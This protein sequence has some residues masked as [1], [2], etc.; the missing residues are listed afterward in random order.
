[1][2]LVPKPVPRRS[3]ESA[4]PGFSELVVEAGLWDLRASPGDW[5]VTAR[6]VEH[7]GGAKEIS[8]R[9]YDSPVELRWHAKNPPVV[10]LALPPIED[11]SPL[12][13]VRLQ[14]HLGGQT[15]GVYVTGRQFRG[16]RFS[17]SAP[18]LEVT[19]ANSATSGRGV[20]DELRG[21]SPELTLEGVR[22]VLAAQD[23]ET[24]AGEI[25]ETLGGEIARDRSTRSWRYGDPS[26]PGGSFYFTLFRRY[27]ALSFPLQSNGQVLDLRTVSIHYSSSWLD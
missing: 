13:G 12:H 14:A 11:G 9:S 10:E 27:G 25:A 26:A 23:Y 22:S 24:L 8:S 3:R 19:V 2:R 20:L 4:A 7:G 16:A 1:M 18:A 17:L 5:H 21:V 6:T 15:V